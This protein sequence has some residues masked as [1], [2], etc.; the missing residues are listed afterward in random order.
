MFIY[1]WIL[2]YSKIC[3]HATFIY[4]LSNA[5][6]YVDFAFIYIFVHSFIFSLNIIKDFMCLPNC[7]RF[8]EPK[9]Y[10]PK[11]SAVRQS[12]MF[13]INVTQNRSRSL[14]YNAFISDIKSLTY[15]L[16]NHRSVKVCEHFRSLNQ[17]FLS[18]NCI[19]V[20]IS[21]AKHI[22]T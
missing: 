16:I 18:V 15:R 3:C 13:L 8:P 12:N 6:C 20:D 7:L 21:V 10:W 17:N 22:H 1:S 11:P 2:A 19:S 14:P 5:H 9:T 4:C